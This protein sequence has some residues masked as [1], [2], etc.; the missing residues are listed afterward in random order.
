[1]TPVG[2]DA[3]R[4]HPVKNSQ[5]KPGGT[6]RYQA[7]QSETVVAPVSEYCRGLLVSYRLVGKK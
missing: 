2:K 5:V 7:K 3:L 4:E 1:M 6:S